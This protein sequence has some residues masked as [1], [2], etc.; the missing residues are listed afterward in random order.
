MKKKVNKLFLGLFFCF[1]AF[2]SV[3]AKPIIQ[4]NNTN[5]TLNF[6][7]NNDLVETIVIKK[8][9]ANNNILCTGKFGLFI[10]QVLQLIKFSVPIIIIAFAVIEFVKAMSAQKQDEIK[11]ATNKLIKRMIIGAI[12][13]VLPTIIDVLLDISGIT[14]STCGW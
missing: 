10:K 3:N 4:M 14:S 12:I 13:F 9:E 6:M 7:Q 8:M 5:S 2:Q 1:F 11:S